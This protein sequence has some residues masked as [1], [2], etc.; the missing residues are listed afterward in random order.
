VLV[1][2]SVQ[3]ILGARFDPSAYVAYDKA[4]RQAV[5]SATAA[6]AAQA[7]ASRRSA[8]SAAILGRAAKVGVGAFA[9]ASAYAVKQA[10]DFEQK[11]NGF[12]AVAGATAQQM[13]LVSKKSKALGA[14]MTLPGTSA[15]DAA[16]VMTE[17]AKGGLSVAD[18]MDA[19]KGS[20][21]LSNAA[22]IGN[23]EAAGYVVKALNA[24]E[25]K[26]RDATRV[27]DLFAAS[28]NATAAEMPEMAQ[29][30]QQAGTVAHG[31]GIPIQDTVTLLGELHNAGI[32]GSDAGTSL[33]TM[34]SSLQPGSVEAKGA[35]KSLGVDVFDAQG[36]FV[37]VRSVVDQYST[38]LGKLNQEQ[39]VAAIR[40]IFGS[41]AQRA[42]TVIFGKGTATYDALRR[43]IQE[44][45]VAADIGQSKMKGFNGAIEG[46]K[47][48][49]ETAA[50]SMGEGLLPALTGGLKSLGDAIG[51]ID[52]GGGFEKLGAGVGEFAALVLS[53]FGQVA[54]AATAIIGPIAGVANALGLLN[55]ST[56]FALVA[57]FGGLKIGAMIGPAVMSAA[58]ALRVMVGAAAGGRVAMAALAATMGGPLR[59]AMAAIAANP[60]GLALAGIGAVVATMINSHQKAA[61]AARDAAEAEKEYAAAISEAN[62]AA[63]D[64]ATSEKEQVTAKREVERADKRLQD[65]K[66]KGIT[67]GKKYEAAL[68][69]QRQ[70]NL[71]YGKAANKAEQDVKRFGEAQKKTINSAKQRAG[72]AGEAAFRSGDAKDVKAFQRAMEELN[73]AYGVQLANEA[74]LTRA[75]KGMI[76]LTESQTKAAGSL[77][78]S[79]KGMPK[80]QRTKMIVEHGPAVARLNSVK[81][82]VAK[83]PAKKVTRLLDQDD[84]AKGKISQLASK[85]SQ[86]G[87]KETVA[88]ILAS[89][90]TAQSKINQLKTSLNSI[91]TLKQVQVQI[92]ENKVSVGG[93]IKAK[94]AGGKVTKP[95][96]TLVGEGAAPEYVIPTESRYRGRAKMLLAAAAKEIG[97]RVQAFRKGGVIGQIPSQKL[98]KAGAAS[99]DEMEAKKSELE[100]MLNYREQLKSDVQSAEKGSKTKKRAIKKLEAAEG[101]ASIAQLKSAIQQYSR[102]ILAAKKFEARDTAKSDLGDIASTKQDLAAEVGNQADFEAQRKEQLEQIKARI[103]QTKTA[104]KAIPKK[105]KKGKRARELNKRMA[106]LKL[107]QQQVKAE[108][109]ESAEAAEATDG[110]KDF[111]DDAASQADLAMT[112]ADGV[113]SLQ[114]AAQEQMISVREQLVTLAKEG[115]DAGDI[116]QAEQAAEQARQELAELRRQQRENQVALVEARAAATG[117]LSDDI[118]AAGQRVNLQVELLRE[119]EATDDAGKIAA[120]RSALTSAEGDLRDLRV[121]S[122]EA[123]QSLREAQAQA[124]ATLTDDI[125]AAQ[126][127]V[128][129]KTQLLEIAQASGDVA[130]I[131][132]ATSALT[133]A[134]A[135]AREL[136]QKAQTLDVEVAQARAAITATLTDDVT[137]AQQMV[138]LRESF[139]AIA[140]ATGDQELIASALGSL[141][142]AQDALEKAEQDAALLPLK[143]DK[144]LAALSAGIADDMAAQE[145]MVDYYEALLV[146]AKETND[147]AKITEAAEALKSAQDALEKAEQDA[148][149]LPL[150]RDKAL[151]ALSAG[152]ADDMAAQEAIVDYY[153]A[154]LVA[155]KATN[156]A[157]KITE[158]AEALK[159][160]QSDALAIADEVRDQ[161]KRFFDARRQLQSE[162]SNVV[163]AQTGRNVGEIN[164]YNYF[165]AQ[166]ADPEA[167]AASTA[168]K[169]ETELG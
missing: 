45:G 89:T 90:D 130:A 84:Q 119:A 111:L 80:N 9:L 104:Q 87:N 105:K 30:L 110:R 74:N 151:A 26:G 145:A 50:I 97:M 7:R 146:A 109:F 76:P 32:K 77:V 159:S 135:A 158:A 118:D 133:S 98:A 62:S 10:A 102:R 121:K 99:V 38:A 122:L 53:A 129:V 162:A 160:A 47:S 165:Q 168:F 161:T 94:A 23:A 88:K 141:D 37:G 54:S 46:V 142:S 140:E 27:A 156:D 40:T 148:A 8:Q 72:K 100:G 78:A 12:Q 18:S 95:E 56:I 61:D 48:V 167:Y 73:T 24:Y 29:A 52:G 68:E 164:L 107:A 124:T 128:S 36:K 81:G 21:L 41:D 143:R 63:L 114:I 59:G 115:G 4:N 116:A 150:K 163:S 64:V 2:G 60:V 69:A 83:M 149:L 71:S 25:L 136:E 134:Q 33:K 65:L 58:S 55:P 155:A 147:A 44:Q 1:A 139:L 66:D 86:V 11:L 85:L 112:Q 154:L 108:K 75:R 169:L 96:L 123:D 57:A 17:L 42:A 79:L 91:P 49:V 43:K 138:S 14:D 19:A 120:A 39:R 106:D 34:L 6:E 5:R 15:K 67:G 28:A 70:A 126:T 157:A 152:I 16:E 117:T 13:E 132:A 113:V 92:R 3:A 51:G 131:A 153:E 93:K 101:K 22:Q 35:I 82:L 31:L 103:D 166:P 20:I 144:A 137:A 125:S 127:A